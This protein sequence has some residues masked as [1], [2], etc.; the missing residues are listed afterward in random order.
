MKEKK[1]IKPNQPEENTY[2]TKRSNPEEPESEQPHQ[3]SLTGFF[4]GLTT[5]L[6]SIF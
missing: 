1:K 5:K 6:S 2:V 4:F 3:P